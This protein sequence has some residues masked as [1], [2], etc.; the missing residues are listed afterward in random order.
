M[1]RAELGERGQGK[2]TKDNSWLFQTS[3]DISCRKVPLI[4]VW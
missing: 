2:Q 4:T 3:S 1:A